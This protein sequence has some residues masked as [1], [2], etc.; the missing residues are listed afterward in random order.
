MAVTFNENVCF[1]AATLVAIGIS[2]PPQNECKKAAIALAA[3]I[4]M[5]IPII[6]LRNPSGRPKSTRSQCFASTFSA[7][8]E[9]SV[10]HIRPDHPRKS[11]AASKF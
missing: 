1:I 8:D 3:V 2:I 6:K 10:A 7:Q 5:F 9:S 4:G 11:Y